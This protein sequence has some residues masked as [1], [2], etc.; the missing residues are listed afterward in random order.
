MFEVVAELLEHRLVQCAEGAF[1]IEI[2]ALFEH[3]EAAAA[4]HRRPLAAQ[5]DCVRGEPLNAALEARDLCG[6]L[7]DSERGGLCVRSG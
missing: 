2:A 5:R 1:C 4:V 6:G 7:G 3:L